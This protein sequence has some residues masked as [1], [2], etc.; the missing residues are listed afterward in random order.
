M[1]KILLVCFLGQVL[2]NL[3]FAQQVDSLTNVSIQNRSFTADSATFARYEF[4]KRSPFY[5]KNLM[6]TSYNQIAVGYN[7][8]KGN[9]MLAQDATKVSNVYLKTEGVAQLKTVTLWGLFSYKK[10]VEDSTMYNHQS[11][12]NLSTPYYFG[13]PIRVSYERAVYNLQALAEK[14]IL[15]NALPIGLGADYRIG[16]HFSTNDP[17]GSISDYQFNLVTTIGYTFFNQLKIGAAYRYGYGQERFNIAY[18]NNSFTQT[19]LLPQYNNYLIN[20]Y[21]EAYVKNIER[22]FDNNQKRQGLDAYANYQTKEFGTFLFNYNH[23]KEDQKFQR[24]NSAGIFRYND[25]QLGK[26]EFHLLWFKNIA[27]KKWTVDLNYIN[28]NGK[29]FN[30]SYSANNYVFNSNQIS[31]KNYLTV[32][33][34]RNTFNYQLMAFRTGEQREDGLTGNDVKFYRLDFNAGFGYQQELGKNSWGF[35]INGHYGL[36]L[37]HHFLVTDANV[38][39]FTET[40]IAQDYLFRTAHTVGGTANFSYSFSAIKSLQT[41]VKVRLTYIERTEIERISID[42]LLGRSRFSSNVSLNLYF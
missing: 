1:K 23:L 26:D 22:D 38:G 15:P 39:L 37:D 17:R 5:L 13:S 35:D 11:R 8:G 41:A 40:V 24:S 42:P 33:K 3:A 32:K 30:Y 25:Y 20:G 7:Y 4:A 9:F 36:P 18:K 27:E 16:S 12:N 29:D 14:N 6:P 21:G 19:T 31:L 34:D 10:T 2:G 28:T